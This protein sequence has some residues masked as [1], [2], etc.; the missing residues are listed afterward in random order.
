MGHAQMKVLWFYGGT[1]LP[2][3]SRA[4]GDPIGVSCGWL[5]SMLD[6]LLA[7]DG[8]IKIC[9]VGLDARNCDFEDGRVR[10]AT[11]GQAGRFTYK[12]IPGELQG[13]ASRII[14]DFCPDVIHIQGTEY[15]YGCFDEAVYGGVPTVVSLQ[16]VISGCHPY[17]NGGLSPNEVRCYDLTP[18]G[19]LK[20][21][22]VFGVQTKW[23]ETR[24]AQEVRVLK[25]HRN[26]IGRTEWD[27]AWVEFYNPAARYFTVNENLRAPFYAERRNP[28]NV[29]R[30]SIYC[31]AAAHYPLKGLHWLMR[32]VASLKDEFPDIQL[33]IAAAE[34][35]FAPNRSIMERLKGQGYHAYLRSLA[36]ELAIEDNIVALPT[37]PAEAVAEELKSAELFVLPSMCENSPNSLGEAMIVGTP[38]IATFVGGV[39]SILK[40]GK[41]GCL[42]PSGDPAALADAIRRWFRHPDEA[43]ACVANA[44]AT[45][46]ARHNVGVNAR[47]TLNVYWE[48]ARK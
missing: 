17:Y 21:H 42:V 20:R 48:I 24:A 3:A 38:S 12:K 2:A 40:D 44:R 30:H 34:R 36:K 22:S 26:F 14:K 46:I 43:E 23:R 19:L 9:V 47:A 1:L 4:L 35:Y 31:G 33:R 45:A 13:R 10:Y 29:K 6:A 8:D 32:A 41:E 16:G 15:F 11:F 5:P 27:R 37:L 18:K 28:A 7:A 39:P 25:A